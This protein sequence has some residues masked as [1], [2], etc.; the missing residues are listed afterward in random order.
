MQLANAALTTAKLDLEWSRV[1]APVN[2][3]IS[4][5]LVDRGA[6]VSQT[7]LLATVVNDEQLHVY[8]YPSEREMLEYLRMSREDLRTL[9]DS[10]RNA[11]RKVYMGL[12]DEKEAKRE[13]E[14]DSADNRVNSD[15]GTIEARAL[16]QNPNRFVVP[17]SFVRV[18]LPKGVEKSLLVPE[19][20]IGQDQ[21][22]RYVSVV[23]EREGKQVVERKFVEVGE[24]V[25]RLRQVTG[26][27]PGDRVV[28]NGLQRARPGAEVKPVDGQIVEETVAAR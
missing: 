12:I 25:G 23:V 21:G 2:G 18:R 6:L 15:T 11:S 1:T 27:T 5:N 17:G 20:A 22:G 10:E 3:R 19:L 13:G 8:F 24:A 9:N 26:L 28:I 4:R 14:M 16:F 7:T